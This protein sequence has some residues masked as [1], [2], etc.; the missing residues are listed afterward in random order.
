MAMQENDALLLKGLELPQISYFYGLWNHL[1][2]DP[3]GPF[4]SQCLLHNF[5]F[6][7]T[8]HKSTILYIY[9]HTEVCINFQR[10]ISC[11]GCLEKTCHR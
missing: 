5:D 6:N 11:S 9:Y 7:K 1:P 3:K 10:N 4:I 8:K 2:R